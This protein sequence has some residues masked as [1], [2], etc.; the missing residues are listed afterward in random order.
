LETIEAFFEES[1][2]PFADD[3]PWQFKS[4]TDF[5]ILEAFGC[6]QNDSGAHNLK[7]R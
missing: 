3:L 6:K 5:L 2:S 1:L 4:F 7:I